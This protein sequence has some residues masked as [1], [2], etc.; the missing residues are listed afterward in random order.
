MSGAHLIPMH[1]AL[2]SELSAHPIEAIL[3][4]DIAGMV[5]CFLDGIDVSDETLALNL[6]DEVGPIP[7]MYLD[8][9]HTIK[10]W[11]S[12]EYEPKAADRLTYP[13]WMN[14][15]KKSCLDYAKE[16]MNEILATHKPPPLSPKQEQAIEG[17]LK[18]ARQYYKDKEMI[19]DKEWEAMQKD[20][21]SANYPY[22]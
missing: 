22:E 21:D 14:S 15:G 17:I 2:S 19:S 16:R 9:P 10:W 3:D 4:D 8:K 6:I 7:G 5:G 11:R 12:M 18:E 1:G 13:E 20:L